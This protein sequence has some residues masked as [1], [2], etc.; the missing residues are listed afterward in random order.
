M[1]SFQVGPRLHGVSLPSV[2]L[3]AREMGRVLRPGGRVLAVDFGVPRGDWMTFIE[4]LHR[5]RRARLPD[6]ESLARAAG[7]EV[8]EGGPVGLRNLSFVLA[9][10]A[11]GGVLTT[12]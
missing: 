12:R 8:L 3:A 10:A 9:R 1:T 5:H 6:V 11:S 7:L 2:R 4:R